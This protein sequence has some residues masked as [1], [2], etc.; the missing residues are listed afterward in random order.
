MK[1]RPPC[2]TWSADGPL[3]PKLP[4]SDALLC[5]LAY[6]RFDRT[7]LQ[8]DEEEAESGSLEQVLTLWRSDCVA[9]LDW[10]SGRPKAELGGFCPCPQREPGEIK[11]DP[12]GSASAAKM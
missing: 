4:R 7:S 8:R 12:A 11:L 3:Q 10:H 6:V 1:I 5:V 9:P 2:S